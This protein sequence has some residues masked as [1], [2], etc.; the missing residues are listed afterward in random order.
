M[1]LSES[2][3]VHFRIPWYR[4]AKTRIQYQY[5]QNFLSA[6]KNSLLVPEMTKQDLLLDLLWSDI[7]SWFL[8]SK[9]DLVVYSLHRMAVTLGQF[10]SWSFCDCQ[11]HQQMSRILSVADQCWWKMEENTALCDIIFKMQTMQCFAISC[12]YNMRR[13]SKPP[14]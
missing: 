2:L 6:Q 1:K 12:L 10:C 13:E 4:R 7:R 11:P 14:S 3:Q 9:Q 5:D 8:N